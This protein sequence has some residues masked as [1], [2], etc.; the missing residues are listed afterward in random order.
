M[1]APVTSDSTLDSAPV[2][3]DNPYRLISL[4][5]IME[6][7]QASGLL[8]HGNNLM[9]MRAP[10]YA[11]QNVPKNIDVDSPILSGIRDA[12]LASM[13]SI[14]K[15]CQALHFTVTLAKVKRVID[16]LRE[17]ERFSYRDLDVA[18]HEVSERLTDELN[19]RLFLAID[20]SD[21]RYYQNPLE[22]WQ[23]VLKEFASTGFDIEEA[24]KCFALNRYTACVFHAMRILEIGLTALGHHYKLSTDRA[25][26]HEIITAIEKKVRA[27]GPGDGVNWRDEQQFGS[28]A[29]TEFRHFKDA[30]RNHAMHVRQ[31]FDDERSRVI[32]E[33]VRA[34][35]GHLATRL[36]ERK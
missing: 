26:W 35:M 36:K 29:C 2:W 15:D 34:F 25:N 32:Y 28:E 8:A 24:G 18:C 30:W 21:V 10:S 12:V 3:A 17:H 16:T 23:V 11:L 5:E 7:I 31:T 22:E 20:A 33:H 14:E 13:Q 19:S 4:G 6:T 9:L 27:L 1:I